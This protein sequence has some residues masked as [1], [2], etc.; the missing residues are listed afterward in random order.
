MH[1]SFNRKHSN[2]LLHI[3]QVLYMCTLCDSTNINKI[4]EFVANCSYLVG[5]NSFN[6]N[7][8]WYLPFRNTYAP[9]LMKLCIMPSNGIV[10]VWLF[11]EF[12][13]ELP[14]DNCT[15]T[16]ILH[17]LVYINKYIYTYIYIYIKSQTANLI[18]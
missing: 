5:G 13:A 17:T 16:T 1:I 15:L 8:G 4:I 12:G 6:G 10:R 14:L 2:F 3:L 9:C 11:P 18:A 7:S